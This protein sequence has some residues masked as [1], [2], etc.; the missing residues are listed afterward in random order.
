MS[1]AGSTTQNMDAYFARIG[2]RGRD[3]AALHEAHA[4]SIP[5]ENLSIQMGE[6]IHL[7]RASLLRKLVER[8]RGGYCFEQNSLLLM[9]LEHLGIMATPYEARVRLNATRLLART[10]MVLIAEVAGQRLLCDVG[11][12][13][14]APLLPVPIDGEAHAQPGGTYRVSAEG[15][16]RV[17][18]WRSE[19][20]WQDLYAIC[21]QRVFEPDLEMANWFTSTHP[22]SKFVTTLTVQLTTRRARHVLRGLTYQR[23]DADGTRHTRE[24]PRGELVPFLRATFGLELPADAQFRALDS[25][26]C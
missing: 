15:E 5:F 14:A 6:P 12:G 3:L 21:P 4:A 26:A 2:Y 17:L 8:R 25:C 24:L 9:A 13:G 19:G 10:H 7:D 1:A 22:Q 23:T 11:F 16:L 20:D 18:Q